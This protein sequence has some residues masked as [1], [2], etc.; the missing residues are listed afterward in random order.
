MIS[1]H[2]I[3]GREAVHAERFIRAFAPAV[4]EI[5]VARAVG[6]QEP[7]ETIEICERV[8]RELGKDFHWTGYENKAPMPHVDDFS[9]A[10]NTALSLCSGDVILW[11]DFDDVI[12][13]E[14][15]GKIRECAG[16]MLSGKVEYIRP[17]GE[18][19]EE[20]GIT[21]IQVF[22]KYDLATQGESNLRERMFTRACR[23]KWHGALHENLHATV[24]ASRIY[25]EL[26]WVHNPLKNEHKDGKRN[27]RILR[28]TTH[29]ADHYVFERGRQA[30]IDWNTG[31]KDE[32]LRQ[33]SYRFLSMA[34]ADY[35]CI[36]ARTYQGK[37]MLAA[38]ERHENPEQARNRL[39]EAIRLMPEIRDAYHQ[40]AEM[41]L[42]DGNPTR[43]LCVWLAAI[44]QR[45]PAAN[46]FQLSERLYG[47]PAADL[48]CRCRRACGEDPSE[49]IDAEA[50]RVGGYKFLLV[51]HTRG[52]STKAMSVRQAWHEAAFSP[53]QLMHVFVCDSDD[54]EVRYLTD[55]G[56]PVK[57]VGGDTGFRFPWDIGVRIAE[58]RKIP[59]VVEVFDNWIP[60]MNWD[61]HVF[62]A[63]E[64]KLN[65]TDA[66]SPAIY[67]LRLNYGDNYEDEIPFRVQTLP[68]AKTDIGE[69]LDATHIHF[70]EGKL[71]T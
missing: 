27:L 46:G 11:A 71:S 43:A 63:F 41:E 38:M 33:E 31:R 66:D 1:L 58:G 36:P 59:I 26:V 13:P 15:A 64:E 22:A 16:D 60:C 18:P 42:S 7:D 19:A 12:T 52:R 70:Q 10:R 35:R 24:N 51:H 45:R 65:A 34:L 5:C 14:M 50:E 62:K 28:A 54:P 20:D 56:V 53:Q 29:L 17:A 9:A 2:A 61:Y 30:F 55:M 39:W 37:I 69:L 68:M 48:L 4:D 21:A 8:C 47:W 6:T 23:P 67:G 40:L 49:S 32:E 3:C 25:S 57:I 44:A